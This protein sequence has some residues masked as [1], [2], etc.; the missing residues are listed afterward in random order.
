MSKPTTDEIF[1]Q[2]RLD[3]LAQIHR[4]QLSLT[5]LWPHLHKRWDSRRS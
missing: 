1:G 4:G 3:K 5:S 2:I